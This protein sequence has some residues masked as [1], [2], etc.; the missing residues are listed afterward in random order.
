M[1]V[2]YLVLPSI[3]AT[4][5]QHVLSGVRKQCHRDR[6]VEKFDGLSQFRQGN[7]LVYSYHALRHPTLPSSPHSRRASAAT[8]LRHLDHQ[9]LTAWFERTLLSLGDDALVNNSVRN[10][11]TILPLHDYS[12]PSRENRSRKTD[13]LHLAQ[14]ILL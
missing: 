1:H 2:H 12:S 7:Q 11:A 4:F 8:I 6:H 3:E 14:K 5:Y 9:E 13:L 10:L